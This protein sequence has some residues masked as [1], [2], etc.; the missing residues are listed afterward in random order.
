V[1]SDKA[2]SVLTSERLSTYFR[3]LAAKIIKDDVFE[4]CS[5]DELCDIKLEEGAKAADEVDFGAAFAEAVKESSLSKDERDEI[6]LKC[7]GFLKDFF[8]GLQ[9]IFKDSLIVLRSAENFFLPQFLDQPLERSSLIGPFFGQTD[10][11]L[12]AAEAK[13]RLMRML[14]WKNRN[15]TRLFWLDIH[16]FGDATGGNRP[17]RALSNGALNLL[18]VPMFDATV[19]KMFR[20]IATFKCENQGRMSPALV[21][22]VLFCKNGLLKSR[23][24]S[25][26]FQ[27]PVKWLANALALS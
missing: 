20:Q 2:T 6:R 23:E 12:S 1:S 15:N 22:A 18:C 13:Y 21:E 11:E 14:D 10:E 8:C 9:G 24:M 26:S 4:A 19:D 16:T 25:S 27:V 5:S 7:F 17:L 3:D